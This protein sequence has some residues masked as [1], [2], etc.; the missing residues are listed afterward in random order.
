MSEIAL[1]RTNIEVKGYEV[2]QAA[3]AIQATTCSSTAV[4]RER[5]HLPATRYVSG[6]A[7][8]DLGRGSEKA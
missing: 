1:R 5:T 7:D 8:D 4:W 6:R 3:D 2:A